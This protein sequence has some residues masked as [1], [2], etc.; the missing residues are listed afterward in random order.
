MKID[1]DSFKGEVTVVPQGATAVNPH[2]GF[3]A[4]RGYADFFSRTPSPMLNSAEAAR[5]LGLT[6]DQLKGRRVR[7][8]LPKPDGVVRGRYLWSRETLAA[9]KLREGL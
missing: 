2:T 6:Y 3:A 8:K 9:Y 7:G 1:Y 5:F 4:N